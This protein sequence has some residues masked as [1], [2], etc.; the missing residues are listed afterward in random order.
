VGLVVVQL[1]PELRDFHARRRQQKIR[2]DAFAVRI[3]QLRTLYEGRRRD[4]RHGA[5]QKAHDGAIGDGDHAKLRRR[6]RARR[7]SDLADSE[8]V[9]TV[10]GKF[11]FRP[12]RPHA[13]A[14]RRR[15]VARPLRRGNVVSGFV[16]IRFPPHRNVR[17]SLRHA[18][19]RNKF[20]RLQHGRRLAADHRGN[21]QNRVFVGMVSGTRTPRGLR[22]RQG[23]SGHRQNAFVELAGDRQSF[24]GRF[25]KAGRDAVSG[26]RRRKRNRRRL[27]NFCLRNTRNI[28]KL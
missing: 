19:R 6:A 9:Q 5:R 3:F 17:H 27:K 21:A 10:V 16:Y 1:S 28:L 8:S 22:Q 7:L 25:G 13:D 18:G 23:S 26:R 12:Q 2:R 20:L 4:Y 15:P 14:H 11:Q 24:A